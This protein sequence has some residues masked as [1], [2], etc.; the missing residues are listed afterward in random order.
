MSLI[1]QLLL[2]SLLNNNLILLPV[3]WRLRP[4]VLLV[5][6]WAQFHNIND[7]RNSTLSSYSLV[8]M[9]INFLQCG[10]QPAVLPCLHALYPDKFSLKTDVHN[11]DMNEEVEP[12]ISE[13]HQTLGE[14]FL[15]FLYYFGHFE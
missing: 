2:V 9:V 8:L 4:L 3:D 12:Y 14:L 5:K 11:I 15:Q 6:K 10:V 1:F 7:A 13:N